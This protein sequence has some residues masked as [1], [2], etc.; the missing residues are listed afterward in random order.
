M[1]KPHS[2]QSQP[3]LSVMHVMAGAPN[4]GAEM[5]YIDM[6]KAMH[7]HGINVTAV[8]RPNATRN[9]ILKEAGLTVHELPF[10]GILD[11]YTPWRLKKLIKQHRPD[12]VQ[13]WMSRAAGKL[14][15]KPS[16][17][18]KPVYIARLGGYY[19]IKKY[20]RLCDHFI[21][22]TPDICRH[23]AEGGITEEHISQINNFAETETD[24]APLNRAALDTPDSAFVF[25]TL[26]RLHKAKAIDTLLE[27][28]TH[29]PEQCVLWIAGQGPDEAALKQQSEALGLDKRVR[30]LGWRTDRAALLESC[31]AVVFPSRY[32]PFGS[33]FV[34]AWEAKRPLVTTASQ[35]PKQYVIPDQD[36]LM[37]DI[38]DVS[39]LAEAMKRIMDD[40]ELCKQLVKNGYQRY[41]NEFEKQIV[42]QHYLDCYTK[43]LAK[44][45]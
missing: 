39:A 1:T 3:A 21:G 8:C 9:T 12:I 22:N 27:A 4:G 26:A 42:V 17:G 24:F 6:C 41:R 30:F 35:G 28:F 5:A 18:K 36:A 23:I 43:A 32:E 2:D 29:L 44:Y 19:N 31:D 11:I 38:D 20:Y 13:A 7:E 25:L 16:Q 34:Q 45:V 14:P 33:T 10:G 15:S 37:V 40:E